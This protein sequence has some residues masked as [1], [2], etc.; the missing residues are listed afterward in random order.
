MLQ[1]SLTRIQMLVSTWLTIKWQR[2]KRQ[3]PMWRL[4]TRGLISRHLTFV[5]STHSTFMDLATNLV[6]NLDFYK[7]QV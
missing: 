1:I 7:K 2:C 5:N 4:D 6:F 3:M